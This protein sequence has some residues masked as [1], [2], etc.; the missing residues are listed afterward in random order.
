[1]FFIFGFLGYLDGII[2]NNYT[3]NLIIQFDKFYCS[4]R[5]YESGVQ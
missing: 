5:S 3:V 1:M 2:D 4:D